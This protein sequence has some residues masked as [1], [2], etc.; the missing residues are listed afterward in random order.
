M[1][2]EFSVETGNGDSA[3]IGEALD[4]TSEQMEKWFSEIAGK[5]F[6]AQ[7]PEGHVGEPKTVTTDDLLNILKEHEFGSKFLIVSGLSDFLRKYQTALRDYVREMSQTGVE[8]AIEDGLKDAV[9]DA[10]K[11]EE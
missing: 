6:N 11:K 10:V 7:M 2:I 5:M 8:K 4:V 1:K 3:H 9:H